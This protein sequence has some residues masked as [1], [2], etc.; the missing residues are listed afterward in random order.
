[1]AIIELASFL[2]DNVNQVIHIFVDSMSVLHSLQTEMENLQPC[3]GMFRKTF[4]S[5]NSVTLHWIPAH[6]GMDGN[7][8]VDK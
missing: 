6:P 7:E 8:C 5:A 4:P 3:Q 2:T 1:M